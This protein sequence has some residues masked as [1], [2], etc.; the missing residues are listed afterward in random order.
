MIDS[1]TCHMLKIRYGMEK[2]GSRLDGKLLNY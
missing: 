1:E 2:F